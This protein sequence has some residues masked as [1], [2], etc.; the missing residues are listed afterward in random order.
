MALKSLADLPNEVIYRILQ[1]LLPIDVSS[2]DLVSKRLHDLARQPVL[3]QDFC[4]KHFRSWDQRW[5]IDDKFRDNTATVDWKAIYAKRHQTDKSTSHQLDSLLSSQ[6]GRIAKSETIVSF[7]YDAE[8]TLVRH[9]R[10]GDHAEDVLAR[11]YMMARF[12]GTE[13]D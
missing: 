12:I 4:R 2:L 3:W 8:D 9:L 5:N 1:Y 10:T 11:R 13:N 7:G 6:S